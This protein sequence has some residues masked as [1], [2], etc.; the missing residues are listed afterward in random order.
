MAKGRQSTKVRKR[1]GAK[2]RRP[3]RRQLPGYGVL[4]LGV[5]VVLA[6]AL[7]AYWATRDDP[8]G[9]AGGDRIEHVHGLG[10]NPA[11]GAVY[12]AAHNGLFRLGGGTAKR[13]GEGNQDT[14]GFTVAGPDH[15][16][17]S[18][19]PGQGGDGPAALG[20]LESTD[21]GVTWTTLSLE[22]QA[23]F[24]ALRFRHDRVY[25]YDSGSRQLKVSEDKQT[26]DDRA[27]LAVRDFV[28]SPSDP[29][30]LAAS[31]ERGLMSSSDGGRSWQQ[32]EATVLLLDWQAEQAL[33]AI[34]TD[35]TVMR[36]ADAGATWTRP[37]E[38]PGEAAAFAAHDDTLYLAT[39]DGEI[40]RS[41][42]SGKQWD[43]IY[44]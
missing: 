18:G 7:L 2:S 12:A 24:H 40:L 34:G 3:A 10:V 4:A 29:D 17:A 39:V 16:L 41:D 19:H 22:G 32:Q 43:T 13:V 1:P 31:G 8:E 28:V 14:M 6:V 33:W 5:A 21:G 25:G 26:W 38:I 20:L 27:Q 11:D 44:S 9:R 23:D 30:L 42:D 37:G 35:G 36:S 15:F